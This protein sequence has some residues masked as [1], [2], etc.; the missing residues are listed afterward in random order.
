MNIG[1][2]VRVLKGIEEGIV[3]RLLDDKLVE[4]EIEDGFTIPVLRNELVII[5]KAESENFHIQENP[6]EHTGSTIR[7][8]KVISEKGIFFAFTEINDQ[9]YSLHLIN[10]SDL[11]LPFTIYTKVGGTSEG[12]IAGCLRGKS[13][14]KISELSILNF[15]SWPT[16]IIQ[17]LFFQSGLYHVKE[18]LLRTIK[19][20]ASNLFKDK[21]LAPILDK[22]A[23][24]FQIDEEN[25][26]TLK[27]LDVDKLKEHLFESNPD[28]DENK[29][30]EIT[31][32]K[33]VIDLHIE[34]LTKNSNQLS[35]DEI[36]DLQID[37]FERNLDAAIAS[38]LD[39]ITFIHGV[40]AGVLKDIIQR[41]LSDT[42]GIKFF[43]DT[44]K[45]KFGY[46]ATLVRIK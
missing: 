30:L 7:T 45:E 46:G 35:A 22:Q 21:I 31:T 13:A 16:F 43:Q 40:G 41:K 19:F 42:Q 10:N 15:E 2:K 9:K 1:D 39:E 24:L 27:T 6:S 8:K 23:Y 4:I 11:T 33:K 3:T 28:G 25:Q 44:N 37:T 26:K 5:D 29:R 32:P 38:G 14:Q 34:S 12:L 18:P 36:L 17:L 20:K